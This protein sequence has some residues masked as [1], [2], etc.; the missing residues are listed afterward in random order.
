VLSHNDVHKIPG[1]YMQQLR[2]PLRI[3]VY[4]PSASRY[5]RKVVC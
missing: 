1:G 3:F 5:Q 4:K 2:P